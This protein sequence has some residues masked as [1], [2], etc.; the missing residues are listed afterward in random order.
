MMRWLARTNVAVSESGIPGRRLIYRGA[1]LI[2]YAFAEPTRWIAF[3]L[4]GTRNGEPDVTGGSV[5]QVA[6]GLARL[7]Q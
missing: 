3:R 4:N 5:D 6:L 7:P 1:Q 2:G